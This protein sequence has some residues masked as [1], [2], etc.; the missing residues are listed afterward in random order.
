MCPKPPL[1]LSIGYWIQRHPILSSKCCILPGLK[2]VVIDSQNYYDFIWLPFYLYMTW[3]LWKTVCACVRI[4][5]Q[6][7]GALIAWM[8]VSLPTQCPP[9]NLHVQSSPSPGGVPPSLV[10]TCL[11][12]VPMVP[13]DSDCPDSPSSCDSLSWLPSR[14]NSQSSQCYSCG[15]NVSFQL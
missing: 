6:L 10:E 15:V 5:S 14:C 13:V 8:S 9:H 2:A 1:S 11:L 7:L 12:S 4:V 3:W